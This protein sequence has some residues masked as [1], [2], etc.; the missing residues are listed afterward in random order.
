MSDRRTYITCPEC[1]EE[2]SVER[3][4]INRFCGDNVLHQKIH[5]HMKQ[6]HK[7]K[8]LSRKWRILNPVLIVSGY[9]LSAVFA[10][11]WVITIIPWAIHEFCE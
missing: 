5:Q 7:E 1:G 9:L 6:E 10:V 3:T 2:I 8:Y 4:W 11:F